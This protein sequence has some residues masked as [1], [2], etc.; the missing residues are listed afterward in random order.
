MVGRWLQRWRERREQAESQ[1]QA[2]QKALEEAEQARASLQ[3]ALE[4]AEF[5]KQAE[6]GARASLLAQQ[7]GREIE[8]LCRTAAATGVASEISLQ[9]AALRREWPRV[10][11]ALAVVRKENA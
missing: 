7:P 8:A 2:L 5:R 6:Q 10:V 3:R 1:A 4:E 11:A 9:D